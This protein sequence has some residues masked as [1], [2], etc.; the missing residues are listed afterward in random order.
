MADSDVN[1]SRPNG[2]LPE[3]KGKWNK[4]LPRVSRKFFLGASY[5]AFGTRNAAITKVSSN[6]YDF[7]IPCVLYCN[8]LACSL[9]SF[10][11]RRLQETGDTNEALQNIYSLYFCGGALRGYL[12]CPAGCGQ[13]RPEELG[14]PPIRRGA[15]TRASL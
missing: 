10:V 12:L 15:L 9:A 2:A 13:I 4:K 11:A 6:L 14:G 3:L 5:V 7:F 1:S 8:C